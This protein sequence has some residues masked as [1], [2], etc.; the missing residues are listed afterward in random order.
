MNVESSL[1]KKKVSKEKFDYIEEKINTDSV[2]EGE[3]MPM[4]RKGSKITPVAA[5]ANRL[6]AENNNIIFSVLVQKAREGNMQAIMFFMER[7]YPKEKLT[8]NAILL[9][10]QIVTLADCEIARRD[11]FK[12]VCDGD[13]GTEHAKDLMT[14]IDNIA[15]GIIVSDEDLMMKYKEHMEV[16][17]GRKPSND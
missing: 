8:A 15:N 4:L 13:I 11:T 14:M 9:T 2:I 5:L 1:A 3:I 6:G 7:F 17:L 10:R 16:V 12:A